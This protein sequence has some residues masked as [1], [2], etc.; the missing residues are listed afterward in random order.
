MNRGYYDQVELLLT[1]LPALNEVKDFALKGGT[2]INLFFRDMPRL[3]VD[4]DLALIKILDRDSSIKLIDSNLEL[5]SKRVKQINPNLKVIPKKLSDG[6]MRSLLIE[7]NKAQ[8]KVEV[9]DIIRGSVYPYEIKELSPKAQEEYERFVEVQSYSFYDLFAGKI[10][11]ALDRQHPRDL[12]D[13]DLLL[14]EDG[15]NDKLRKTFI[16]YLI[17]HNR[18]ISE[19]INPNRLDIT[20]Q[21]K[22]NFEGMTSEPVTVSELE[23]AREKIISLTQKFDDAEKEF[24]MSFKSGEP[25]WDLLG[26]EAVEKLPAVQWKLLNISKMSAERHKAAIN[27]LERKLEL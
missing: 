3:S 15:F 18:P 26:L 10:C 1:V 23:E 24:L 25:K 6:F 7:N 17:S 2:S 21:F 27:E 19:L 9:N 4:I 13:V 20:E 11:A 12:F 14:K 5:F 22:K 8:I 16:I